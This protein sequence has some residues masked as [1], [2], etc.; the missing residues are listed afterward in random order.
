[1]RFSAA[2]C[3]VLEDLLKQT[4]EPFPVCLRRGYTFHGFSRTPKELAGVRLRKIRLKSGGPPYRPRPSFMRLRTDTTDARVLV[5]TGLIRV[6][7]GGPTRGL[8]TQRRVLAAGG[9]TNR[10]QR[11]GRAR[12]VTLCC[13]HGS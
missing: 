6:P 4:P 11:R 13:L 7:N 10:A 8:R 2:M 12:S 5:A 1:M 3:H 9:G